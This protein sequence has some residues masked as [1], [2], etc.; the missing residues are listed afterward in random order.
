MLENKLNKIFGTYLAISF[1][2]K[3]KINPKI[4]KS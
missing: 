1:V 3:Q 4:F 2:N